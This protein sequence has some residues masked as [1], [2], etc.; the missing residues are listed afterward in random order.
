MTGSQLRHVPKPANLQLY[1]QNLPW[2]SHATHLGHELHEEGNMDFDCKCKRAKFID[3]SLN[4]RETFKFANPHQILQAV[5]TY[6]CDFYGSMLWDLFDDQTEQLYRCWNTCNKLCWNIPR[7][8]HTYFVDNLLSCGLP[9]I[10]Q[11]I[12]SRYCKFVRSLMTSPSKE[13]AVLARIAGR[14]ASSVTGRNILNIY[15]ETNLNPILSPLSKLKEAL[16]RPTPVPEA[17]LWRLRLLPKYVHL[18]Q[19][20]LAKCDDTHFID[21]LIESLCST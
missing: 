2:V 10:R 1:G 6:C 17:D 4:I 9:S 3:N 12:L 8:T 7:S 20:L 15:L 11:R 21:E 16:S 13:V 14:N 18:R 5:Q 19:S